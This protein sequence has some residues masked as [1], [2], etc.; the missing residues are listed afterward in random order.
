MK[1]NC[2]FQIKMKDP[3]KTLAADQHFLAY[4]QPVYVIS[5]IEQEEKKKDITEV[6]ESTSDV[7]VGTE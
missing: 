5:S 3:S 4:Q 7:V 6:Q 1:N 2:L